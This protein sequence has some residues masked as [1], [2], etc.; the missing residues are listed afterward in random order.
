MSKVIL[1]T[2]VQFDRHLGS[3]YHIGCVADC[4]V[5]ENGFKN[6]SLVLYP[7]AE[8]EKVYEESKGGGDEVNTNKNYKKLTK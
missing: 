1:Q 4:W 3:I 5:R 6:H 7:L 2:L 8:T